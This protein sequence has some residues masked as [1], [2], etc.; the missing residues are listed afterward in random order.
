LFVA[1]RKSNIKKPIVI[2]V[3]ITYLIIMLLLTL[4]PLFISS[5]RISWDE[6]RLYGLPANLKPFSLIAQQWQNVLAGQQGAFRQ[7]FGNII[8]FIPVGI[9]MPLLFKKT[10]RFWRA[11]LGAFLFTFTI[12]ALQLILCIAGMCLREFDVDDLILNTLGAM[13]GHGIY[14]ILFHHRKAKVAL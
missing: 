11:L 13:L 5:Y 14:K 12:E 6:I 9:L 4:Q 3:S 10:Q 7:F 1:V 2:T 8:M